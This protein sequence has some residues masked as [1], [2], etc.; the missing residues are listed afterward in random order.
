MKVEIYVYKHRLEGI[1]ED[2]FKQ[3][4]KATVED[5]LI[6][7]YHYVIRV[8]P[9]KSFDFSKA[10]P[11]EIDLCWFFAKA[12]EKTPDKDKRRFFSLIDEELPIFIYF[13]TKGGK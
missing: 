1:D 10:V 2:T 12:W 6:K 4:L 13:K 3:C 11:V 7:P 5:L 8:K 9:F